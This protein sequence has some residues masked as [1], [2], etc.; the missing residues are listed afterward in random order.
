MMIR[1]LILTYQTQMFSGSAPRVGEHL[2]AGHQLPV[3]GGEG[4]LLLAQ[5]ASARV[6]QQVERKP[7]CGH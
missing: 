5:P 2:D 3:L 4:Q 7:V 6:R 1:L